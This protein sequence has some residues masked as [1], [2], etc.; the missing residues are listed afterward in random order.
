MSINSR[1]VV[2]GV[3][4]SE[5]AEHAF[6]WYLD[7]VHQDGNQVALIHIVELP[8]LHSFQHLSCVQGERTDENEEMYVSPEAWQATINREGEKEKLLEDHFLKTL[9]EKKIPSRFIAERGKPGEVIVRHAHEMK[10]EAIVVGCRGVGKLR[11]TIL[12]SVSDYVLH[13]AHCPVL[14][15]RIPSR[16]RSFSSS[17]RHASG[18]SGRFRWPSGDKQRHSSGEKSRHGSASSCD[19]K[20][21]R[22]KSGDK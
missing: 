22:H 4:S 9:Q 20:K 14:I 3:D 2:I 1:I 6:N 18:D 16:G 15:C 19:L 7:H 8:S 12:G 5:C 17:S 11:R 21:T 10:A 13:H